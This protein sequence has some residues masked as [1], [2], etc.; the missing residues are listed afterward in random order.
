MMDALQP[1]IIGLGSY[2]PKKILSNAELESM[3]DTS[4]EWIFSRTGIRERRIATPEEPP[5]VMGAA[6]ARIALERCGMAACDIDLVLVATMT[7]DYPS[8]STAA[9]IQHAIGAVKAAAFDIQ[10]ACSGFLYALSTAK[11]FVASGMY[12]N[13]LV[14]TAEKMS[15]LVDYTDRATC[16]LFGDGASAAVISNQGT[17]LSLGSFCLGANGSLVD[18]FMVPAGGSRMPTGEETLKEGQHFIKMQGRELFK[19]AVQLMS[20]AA[21]ECLH[22][23]SLDE[24]DVKWIVPHQANERIIDAIGKKFNGNEHKVFKNV[25]KYGNTSASS[26][27]IALDELQQQHQL[28][29]GEH[30]LL[31]AFGAGVTWGAL[32]LT[33]I[34]DRHECDNEHR[35]H[36]LRP[37]SSMHEH[38]LEKLLE[39]KHAEQAQHDL[40]TTSI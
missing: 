22:K 40:T 13:V 11:A 33:H 1:R 35:Q 34:K 28:Q 4:D 23:A 5:S 27:G 7:P 10:A 15:S 8:S 16:I 39:L 36:T 31:L 2:L 29:D 37:E 21:E 3:V 20:A 26:I 9:L 18:I 6:A 19:H 38:E 24:D 25:H 12:K 30:I 14:I 32:L 17:G